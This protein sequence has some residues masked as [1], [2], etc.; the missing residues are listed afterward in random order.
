MRLV[1][2]LISCLLLWGGLFFIGVGIIGL[3]RLPDLYTRMHATSKCDS[4]GTAMVL[5]AMMLQVGGY[6]EII[7]L[8]LIFACIWSINPVVAHAI[9]STAYIR[10]EDHYPGTIFRDCYFDPYP[11]RES[12]RREDIN[13]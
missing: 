2:D 10:G 7:K 4:L 8:L 5:V 12:L 13:A 11:G 6:I 3:V 1:L 9:S